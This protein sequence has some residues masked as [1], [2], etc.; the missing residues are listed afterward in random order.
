MAL[1]PLN[2]GAQP[3]G[4]MDLVDTEQS[5]ILG[6]EVM[7]LTAASRVNTSTEKAAADVL[8]G[9]LYD[10]T[11]DVLNRVG[12]TRA[13][14][15]AN[16]PLYLSDDGTAGYGT[17][18]GQVIGTPAGLLTVGTNIG[19]HTAAGSGKVTLWDKP[20][21]YAVTTD[22]AAS[23]FISA[24]PALGLTPGE[25]LGFGSSTDLGKLCHNDCSNLVTN[26]GVGYLVEV[27]SLPSLVT[28][29]N[30]LVGATESFDRF[31]LEFHAGAGLR[32]IS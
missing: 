16:Y 7:T 10:T 15:A 17:L 29:P 25:V 22:A 23:D 4:Q 27:G 2:P 20:G 18:F 19:P 11:P 8:D 14:A 5:S 6:G 9:Y 21:R 31:E 13:S 24:I 1:F 26:S 12:V 32:T 30:R 28:T 3:L